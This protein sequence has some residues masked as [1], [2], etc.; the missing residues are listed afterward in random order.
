MKTTKKTQYALRAMIV[1]SKEKER[2]LSYIAKK[3]GMPLKYLEKVFSDLETNNLVRAK[4]GA[5]GG[6]SLE[7]SPRKITLENVFDAVGE[8]IL[9]A[10]CVERGC[11]RDG[12]CEASRAWKRVGDEIKKSLSSIKLSDLIE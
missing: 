11:P 1:L 5:K 9:V 10:D 4:R 7:R 8:E 12:S 2:P 6:Y 3:E